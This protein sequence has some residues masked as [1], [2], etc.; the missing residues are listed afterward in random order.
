MLGRRRGQEQTRRNPLLADLGGSFPGSRDSQS[1]ATSRESMDDGSGSLRR[2]NAGPGTMD[3]PRGGG[4]ATEGGRM[5]EVS[6]VPHRLES[7]GAAVT[8]NRSHPDRA[9]TAMGS[10]AARGAARPRARKKAGIG[11]VEATSP[12][13]VTAKSMAVFRNP[14]GPGAA[15]RMEAAGGPRTPTEFPVAG[16]GARGPDRTLGEELGPSIRRGAGMPRRGIP[17]STILG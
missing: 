2:R 4:R 9:V 10:T 11:G 1:L 17:G 6:R 15:F 16:H 5:A 8:R 13:G 12:R 3:R 14:C 7:E